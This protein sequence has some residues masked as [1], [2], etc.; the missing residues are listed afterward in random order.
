MR[1]HFNEIDSTS[2]F[3]K[4]NVGE[5]NHGDWVSA[6]YQSA[7]HGQAGNGW[8]SESGRNVLLSLLMKPN[9]IP[10]CEGF[11]ITEVVTL[12]ILDALSGFDLRIKWPNDIYAGDRKLC[13]I[14][15][16]TGILGGH[17]D[18]AIVGIGLNVNQTCFESDAPNPVSLVQL[19][20]KVFNVNEMAERVVTMVIERYERGV[21]CHG[22]YLSHLYR[23]GE[24]H[25]FQ[26]SDG[27]IFEAMIVDVE[28][29]G[30]LA[31]QVRSGEIEHFEF[32]S[33]KYIL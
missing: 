10:A 21:E 9:K 26:R 7:G 16:E 1:L 30:L 29:N 11:R 5:F 15:I 19:S 13:G 3:L 25:E 17:I 22:E 14:L 23:R 20:G 4:N 8:E 32:K 2:V 27:G 6:D 18:K 28:R 31:M 33:I 24:W 12:G